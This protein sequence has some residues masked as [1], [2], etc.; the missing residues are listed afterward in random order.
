MSTTASN[1]NI[2]AVHEVYFPVTNVAA[3]IDWYMRNFA[4]RLVHREER[5]ATLR[6]AEGCLLTL[7]ESTQLNRYDSPPINFK[8]HDARKAH[9]QLNKAE[10]RAQEP[11]TFYHYVDFDVWDPDGNPFNVISEPAWP[12]TPNNYFRID[13]VFLGVVN[14]DRMLAWYSDVLGAEIEY[15]FT[16]PTATLPEARFRCFR[17]IPVNIVESPASVIR[18]RVC[19]FQTANAE[20]DY[21]YLQSKGVPVTKL[22]EQDG[23]RRF[24]FIDPEGRELGIV[25]LL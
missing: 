2:I 17:G 7:L 18:H 16:G 12:D 21:N 13:G 4:L 14:F 22:V 10:V 20:A 19:E 15:A 1:L 3:S 25:E 23:K 11:D 5:Q 6:L 24:S 9:A 8:A